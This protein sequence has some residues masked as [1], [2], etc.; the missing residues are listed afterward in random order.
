MQHPS[1]VRNK[2]LCQFEVWRF[3][4]IA[5]VVDDEA[6]DGGMRLCITDGVLWCHDKQG[7][8]KDIGF[9]GGWGCDRDGNTGIGRCSGFGVDDMMENAILAE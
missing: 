2:N 4:L 5:V 8:R 6:G 3:N 9:G 7:C 1:S